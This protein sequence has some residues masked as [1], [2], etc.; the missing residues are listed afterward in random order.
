MYLFPKKYNHK[1]MLSW[2]KMIIMIILI[3]KKI[4]LIFHKLITFYEHLMTLIHQES[5]FWDFYLFLDFFETFGEFLEI[6]INKN[7]LKKVK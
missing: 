4:F 7:D 6:K 1:Y 2:F 5:N 3:F